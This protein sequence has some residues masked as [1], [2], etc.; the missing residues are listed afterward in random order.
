MTLQREFLIKGAMRRE[1][2][3][4]LPFYLPSL[5][6]G[7]PCLWLHDPQVGLLITSWPWDGPPTPLI[8]MYRIIG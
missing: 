6:S 4:V 3:F 1:E 7:L 8:C 5:K 2:D